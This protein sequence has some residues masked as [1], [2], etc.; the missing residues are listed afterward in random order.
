[1]TAVTEAAAFEG[2]RKRRGR[3]PLLP[4]DPYIGWTPYAWL[5]YLPIFFIEPVLRS[6]HGAATAAYWAFMLV[7]LAAFLYTYFRVHWVGGRDLVV[8]IGAQLALGVVYAPFNTGSSVFIVYAACFVGQ[9][10]NPRTAWR[11]LATIPVIGALTSWAIG[12]PMYFW[13]SAVILAPLFGAVLMHYAQ[14]Q[15]AGR[16]LVRAQEEI[17]HLAAVAERERIARDLCTTHSATRCR[18]WCSRRSSPASSSPG[19]VSGRAPRSGMWSRSRGTPCRTCG[20]PSAVTARPF[21]WKSSTRRRSSP[22]PV[23]AAR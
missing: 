15:R 4:D 18:S 23:S 1:V 20:R 5:I 2:G 10:E 19:T 11:M 12:A 17:E 14:A 7:G 3:F 16:K 13:L 9:I 8:L 6:W 22:R 21:P